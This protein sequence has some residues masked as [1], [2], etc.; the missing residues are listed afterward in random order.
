MFCCNLINTRRDVHG[1]FSELH[2]KLTVANM[3]YIYTERNASTDYTINQVGRADSCLDFALNLPVF[4]I[5]ILQ[6]HSGLTK[7][8]GFLTIAYKILYK[9][10]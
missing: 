3:M 10:C 6:M 4:T 7:N 5:S 9:R 8:K 2:I 1:N